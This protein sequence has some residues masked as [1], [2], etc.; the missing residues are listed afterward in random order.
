MPR[1]VRQPPKYS[2]HKA[3]GQA[4]VTIGGVDIYLG[5][6]GSRESR[7]K[8]AQTIKEWEARN[9]APPPKPGATLTIARLVVF[10]WR[11]A[12]DY[13]RT[14]D[15]HVADEAFHYRDAL[16]P[17]LK[18]YSRTP[19]ADFGPLAL[20]ASRR[21]MIAMGWARTYINR[22]VLRVKHVFKWAVGEQLLEPKVY[23]ALRAVEGLQKGKSDARESAK[24]KPVSDELAA[25]VVRFLSPQVS[26]MLAL[27]GLTGMRSTE[28]CIMRGCDID[29]TGKPWKYRP[30][31]HK[32]AHHDHERI[33]DL[34]PQAR[35]I[36]E[37]FLKPDLRAYLFSPSEAAEARRRARGEQRKTPLSCGNV[38]GSNRKRR[39]RR[40]PADDRYDRDGYRHAILRACDRAFPP[41]EQFARQRVP[42][43]GRK[44]KATRW[45]TPAE[46]QQ[47][48]GPE[49]WAQLQA[50]RDA[51]RFHPHQLRHAAATRWRR[52]FGAEIV[53]VMLGDRTPRMVEIYAEADREKAAEIAEKIG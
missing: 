5:R 53:G 20:K 30:S 8:Y 17:V 18:L 13:Y 24:V 7:E 42:A 50:W 12:R 34:G 11:H 43:R 14:P 46:W 52:E 38:P 2:K 16:N 28:I 40:R 10:F 41:P 47:R 32:T 1:L 19:A 21:E 48:L 31:F 26:A 3:S 4:V 27:Q 35:A 37:R 9:G 25:A 6:H 51:R 22:Q 15:G 45:E 23:E 44:T 36:I 33:V 39:S 49:K 29:T